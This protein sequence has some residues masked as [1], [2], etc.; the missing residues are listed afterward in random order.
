MSI[1]DIES[2]IQEVSKLTGILSENDTFNNRQD[3]RSITIHTLAQTSQN[4]MFS[5]LFSK[6]FM[7]LKYLKE[8]FSSEIEP[9]DQPDMLYNFDGYVKNG[10][11][12]NFFVYVEN[13]IRQI[14]THYEINKGDLNVTS[15]TKTFK[16]ITDVNK[17]DLFKTITKSDIELFEFYCYLRNTMHNGG[18]HTH[19]NKSI[20]INDEHSRFDTNEVTLRLIENSPNRTGFKDQLLVHE[21]ISKLLLKINALIPT[22]DFIEHRFT[23]TGFN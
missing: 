6:E 15:I 20:S 22:N 21:Q 16:N 3:V 2:R 19:S 10:F 12:I 13:H 9:Q 11:F 5:L 1:K 4:Y 7:N 14:A 23:N 18:F 8:N 17:I